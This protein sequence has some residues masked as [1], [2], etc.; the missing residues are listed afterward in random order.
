MNSSSNDLPLRSPAETPLPVQ[1]TGSFRSLRIALVIS[2]L[3]AGGAEK[4]FVNLAVGL[5]QRGHRV[6]VFSLD[7]R[8]E[9]GR[10]L[11]VRRLEQASIPL[12]FSQRSWSGWPS[13][14]QVAGLQQFFRENSVEIASSFLFRA[15]L[16]TCLAARKTRQPT[17]A[18]PS[19]LPAVLGLRQAEPRFFVRELEKWC[20]QRSHATVCVSRQVAQHYLGKRPLHPLDSVDATRRGQVLVIPNGVARPAAPPDVP[21]DVPPDLAACFG[22]PVVPKFGD[23]LP[24]LLFVGRLTH[25]KGVDELLAL[26]PKLLGLLP[27]FRLVLLGHGPLE[28][29]LRRQAAALD[30]RD[31]IHFLG[32]RP[33]PSSYIQ[34]SAMVLLHSRWEGQPN[35]ILEAM[36]AGKPFVSTETHGVADIFSPDT[37]ENRPPAAL[38]LAGHPAETSGPRGTSGIE[39][40]DQASAGNPVIDR[41]L[42]RQ[43]QVVAA[44]DP[45]AYITAIT[46]L[47]RDPK[48]A[49]NIGLWNQN[50]VE[51]H[52]SIAQFVSAHEQVFL[53][54]ARAR[55]HS[56]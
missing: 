42:A 51:N 54:L 44:Q 33:N 32:W 19:P 34:A 5:Q 15:N 27:G 17:D 47:A 6:F 52:F 56:T 40:L 46:N 24:V 38:E 28:K 9:P 30:C 13:R 37:P 4:N 35:A 16:A 26:S 12:S 2:E 48:I 39:G 14:V 29:A 1:T 31:R 7:P 22:E 20:L 36:S 25:Q 50:H 3:E 18:G 43:S 49:K 8:P 55:Q 41:S 23:S 11:L 53:K 45:Q 21:P 10:D